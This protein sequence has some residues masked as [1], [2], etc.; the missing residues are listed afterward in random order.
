M[1]IKIIIANNIKLTIKPAQLATPIV[2][3]PA[4]EA[5]VVIYKLTNSATPKNTMLA[6]CL[7]IYLPNVIDTA[8]LGLIPYLLR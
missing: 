6:I 7:K 3:S 4:F 8:S 1:H 2:T 5:E